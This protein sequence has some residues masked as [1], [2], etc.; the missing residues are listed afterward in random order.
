MMM[1]DQNRGGRV[2]E[3]LVRRK[4]GDDGDKKK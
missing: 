3:E 1:I 4:G 2:K